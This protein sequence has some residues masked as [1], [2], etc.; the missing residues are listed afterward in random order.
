MLLSRFANVLPQHAMLPDERID[1]AFAKLFGQGRHFA[2]IPAADRP[3]KQAS[4]FFE[5][6]NVF[7]PFSV[8]KELVTTTTFGT[9]QGPTTALKLL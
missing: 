7:E 6:V 1:C 9:S 4:I 5:A 8:P 3:F 2:C